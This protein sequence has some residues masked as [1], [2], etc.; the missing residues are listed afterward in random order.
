M[1]AKIE[2]VKHIYGLDTGFVSYIVRIAQLFKS[3]ITIENMITGKKAD[4]RRIREL[5]RLGN[6]YGT[7]VEIKAVGEDEE[8]AVDAMSSLF[9]LFAE[10]K[11]YDSKDEDQRINE[12]FSRMEEGIIKKRG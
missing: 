6:T 7:D 2:T 10:R 11:L 8:D 9:S 5:F 3:K 12:S 4:A 1:H